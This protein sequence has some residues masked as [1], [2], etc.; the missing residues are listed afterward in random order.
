MAGDTLTWYELVDH[1]PELEALRLAAAGTRINAGHPRWC[2][3]LAW[4]HFR[5]QLRSLVG[6]ASHHSNRRMRSYVA[7]DVAYLVIFG[8]LP[9]CPAG[10]EH[11]H[12]TR[13]RAVHT[14]PAE[15]H[16]PELAEVA[17]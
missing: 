4:P 9:P 5:E 2:R 1:V 3:V 10:C 13:E 14:T 6:P 7:W 8:G 12:E 11:R 15:V 17:G 16:T